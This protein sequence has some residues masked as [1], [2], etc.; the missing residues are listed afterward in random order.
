MQ[1]MHKKLEG[2][3]YKEY[4]VPVWFNAWL[5]EREKYLAIVP[6]LNT[7]LEEISE[8]PELNEVKDKISKII[9]S[10]KRGT[11]LG[12]SYLGASIEYSPGDA[13]NDTADQE[14]TLYYSRFKQIEVALN[15]VNKKNN[16]RIVVFIDDLDRCAPDKVLE[17]LESIKIFLGIS[18]FI[19]V[20]GLNQNV[21][22]TCINNKYKDLNIKGED[23]VKKIIQ[24]PF[25][26]PEWRENELKDYVNAITGN[27]ETPYKDL[28]SEFNEVVINGLENNPREV[29]RFINSYI[30]T[31]EVFKKDELDKE[32]LLLLQVFQ[33]RW[34]AFYSTLFDFYDGVESNFSKFC[35]DVIKSSEDQ[36]FESPYK[37]YFDQYVETKEFL[38][39]KKAK[40]IFLKLPEEANL[41]KYR[42]SGTAFGVRD[43]GMSKENLIKLLRENITEFNN[44]RQ[45]NPEILINL[46]NADLRGA[47]MAGANLKDA[48]LMNANLM[49]AKLENANLMNAKLEDANLMNAKL[50]DA[51]LMNAKLEDANLMNA[52]L[53]NTNLMNANLRNG[54]LMNANLNGAG[55]MNAKL[56]D[57]KLM[58]AKLMNAKLMNAKLM[59]ANLRNGKLMNAN[60]NGAGLM[61]AKMEGTIFNRAKL[62]GCNIQNAIFD[63]MT[64]FR[65]ADIDFIT[66]QNLRGSNWTEV[67]KEK[68]DEDTLNKIKKEFNDSN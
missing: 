47:N 60:L 12:I 67:D 40:E 10:I 11:R 58:N 2:G 35:E 50:E 8:R 44:F 16:L 45:E 36:D 68:W 63:E 55:L 7:I 46:Q 31:Q 5:Y 59:N 22:E 21:I 57:A 30:A 33:F 41:D 29:K 52:K 56:E 54:K 37:D 61:N 38:K 4:V 42:R 64:D 18:G 27:L 51:N 43:E 28:F 20:L 49:N 23:Y 13:E 15:E 48:N 32:I 65:G 6:L 34:P 17:V 9:T 53:M 24:I 26:I 3:N 1:I 19:Y 25:R 39:S 62:R 14:D 66:I